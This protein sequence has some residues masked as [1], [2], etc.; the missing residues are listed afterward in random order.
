M[1]DLPRDSAM[2]SAKLAIVQSL[3]NAMIGGTATDAT[4]V[5]SNTR[6]S[7]IDDGIEEAGSIPSL[8]L[9]GRSLEALSVCHA[10]L[11]AADR[12]SS[13]GALKPMIAELRKVLERELLM[14]QDIDLVSPTRRM[15]LLPRR[16]VLI[17]RPSVEKYVDVAV[18]CR[19]F[20]RGDR[21]LSL[22]CDGQG[23]FV[24]DLG[25]TN[26]HSIQGELLKPG[27]PTALPLGETC[28]EIGATRDK[29]ALAKIHLHRPSKDPGAVVVRLS[30]TNAPHIEPQPHPWPTMADD[31]D[32]RWVIFREQIGVSAEEDCALSVDE[33]PP[34]I[35]AAI[36][37][38][39]G[40]W[41]V[42]SSQGALQV[43]EIAFRESVPIPAGAALS[44]SGS[45]LRAEM[46]SV[47]T[48][49]GAIDQ[50]AV[51]S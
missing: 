31:V 1:S 23:W 7:I 21:N 16:S 2:P 10:A 14:P 36:R 30:G 22:F 5:L 29:L 20:S 43:D 11:R 3:L 4:V 49:A 12:R 33:G 18:N 19:W 40:F 27:H 34:G 15:H 42:P 47:S 17:G 26:G 45:T 6:S 32:Q 46:R 38:Q 28:I 50:C 9:G 13:P 39:N 25:S 24:E 41:I 44:L 48:L 51:A 37:Y 8:V 35:L